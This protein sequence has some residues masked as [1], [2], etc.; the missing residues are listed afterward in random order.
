M[1]RLVQLLHDGNFSCVI[2]HEGVIRVFTGRGVSDL[3]T[4]L[5]EEPAFLYHSEVADKVVGKAAAALMTAGKVKAVSTDLIS[6]P[7]RELLQAAGISVTFGEETDFIKNR[8][9]DD[10]CPLEKRCRTAAT[11]EECLPLIKE[12]LE[13]ART[14]TTNR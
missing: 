3:Y 7:A 11:A 14:A 10:L 13:N 1:K 8:S 12:F 5:Q 4:L 2:R 6:R 9:G